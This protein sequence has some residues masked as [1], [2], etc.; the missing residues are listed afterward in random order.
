MDRHETTNQQFALFVEATGYQTQAQRDGY[1]WCYIKN[2]HHFVQVAG[3]NWQHPNGPNSS[4]AH[5]P[6]H[7]VVC[8]SWHDAVAYATWAGKYLPTEAQW[9]YAARSGG[10][11]HI[12]ALQQSDHSEIV[13]K[14]NVWQGRWPTDNQLKDGFFYTAPVGQ[15]EP[16]T[17]GLVDMIG[18][19]WEW[20]SDWYAHNYYFESPPD[21]PQGPPT[22]DRR[23]VRGGSWFCSPNY[24]GAYTSHY[25]GASPPDHAFN[26]VGFRCAADLH[27][28]HV[29]VNTHTHH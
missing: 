22:G 18:N 14:A 3:A 19:V 8:I 25:R 21:N 6:D 4:I 17:L 20:N 28:N 23:V 27:V 10:Q 12:T 15:F 11:Q 5:R 7:P 2:N 1:A 16:N 13:V 24:C 9:E 26:N 29:T